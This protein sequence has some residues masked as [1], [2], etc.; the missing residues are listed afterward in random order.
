MFKSE[1]RNPLWE[2]YH[3]KDRCKRKPTART[4]V[5][6]FLNQKPGSQQSRRHPF[7]S[8]SKHAAPLSPMSLRSVQSYLELL[9]QRLPQALA[10]LHWTLGASRDMTMVLGLVLKEVHPM[11]GALAPS[12]PNPSFLPSRHGGQI[13]STGKG[14][15][16]DPNETTT[17]SPFSGLTKPGRRPLLALP[18]AP[19]AANG[20]EAPLEVRAPSGRLLLEEAS[21]FSKESVR[22]PRNGGGFWNANMGFPP[23]SEAGGIVEPVGDMAVIPS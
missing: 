12:H 19:K 3:A 22:F 6:F 4:R 7:L 1:I 8:S 14:Q 21:R 10:L 18:K 9:P 5:F 16:R 2:H 20:V 13:H 11:P 15:T 23:F 17:K